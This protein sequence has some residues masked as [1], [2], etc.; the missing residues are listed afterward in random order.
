M[1]FCYSDPVCQ[2]YV[3]KV[4][5]LYACRSLVCCCLVFYKRSLYCRAEFQSSGSSALAALCCI[6]P[7]TIQT[8]A[9]NGTGRRRD[10]WMKQSFT[11]VASWCRGSPIFTIRSSLGGGKLYVKNDLDHT[12]AKAS[13]ACRWSA[14]CLL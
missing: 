10:D 7:F 1:I 14:W 3:C 12:D 11:V 13:I 4:V 8:L 5:D 2:T 9:Y 6:I